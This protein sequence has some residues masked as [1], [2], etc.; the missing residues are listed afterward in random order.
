MRLRR[1]IILLLKARG[2]DFDTV[3]DR[4]VQVI[5]INRAEVISS[6]RQ[7]HKVQARSLLCFFRHQGDLV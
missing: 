3:V 7:P 2:H 6:G 4:V 5:G 1:Y